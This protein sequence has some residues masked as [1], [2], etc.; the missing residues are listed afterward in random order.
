M[1]R[2]SMSDKIQA[3]LDKAK[4]HFRT[5]SKIAEKLGVSTTTVARWYS[6]RGTPRLDYFMVLEELVKRVKYTS[7]KQFLNNQLH[8][9]KLHQLE[10]DDYLGYTSIPK[11]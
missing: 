2:F 6:G 11:E 4:I 1:E 10:K 5:Y 3:V 8:E 9:L 7:R